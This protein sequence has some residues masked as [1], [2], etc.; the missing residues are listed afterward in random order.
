[1]EGRKIQVRPAAS[2]TF[3]VSRSA[4]GEEPRRKSGIGLITARC[5]D[6]GGIPRLWHFA[7]FSP[8]PFIGHHV[9]LNEGAT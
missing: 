5:Q 9:P 8:P 3:A 1:M 7:P 6:I 2:G 4:C